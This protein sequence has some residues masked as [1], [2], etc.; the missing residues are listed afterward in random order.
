MN[1][2]HAVPFLEKELLESEKSIADEAA[3]SLRRITGKDYSN[4]L[5]QRTIASRTEEDWN[6]LKASR[7]TNTF[8]S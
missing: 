7:R 5:S 6:L 4:R 1:N 3:E 8:V 2:V